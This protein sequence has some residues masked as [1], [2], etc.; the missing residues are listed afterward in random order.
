M[1]NIRKMRRIA[2]LPKRPRKMIRREDAPISRNR[3]KESIAWGD[4]ELEQRAI[5]KSRYPGATLPERIVYKKLT[6]LIGEDKFIFQRAEGGGRAVI[7]GFVLDFVILVRD[8]PILLEVAG[9]YW[10]QAKDQYRDLERALVM[11]GLGYE[12]YELGEQ[13]IYISDMHLE[14]ILRSILDRYMIGV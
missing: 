8:P 2:R 13:D 12:Y 5:P 6:E 9:T 1:K 10:H 4:D 14:T 7:G 11:Q 3:K